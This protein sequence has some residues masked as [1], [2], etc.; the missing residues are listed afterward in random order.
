MTD[1]SMLTKLIPVVKE[2]ATNKDLLQALVV[3]SKIPCE[4]KGLKIEAT[5]EGGFSFSLDEITT[6]V[7]EDEQSSLTPPPQ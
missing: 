4:M 7:K 1:L 3:L 2:L 6:G 5:P